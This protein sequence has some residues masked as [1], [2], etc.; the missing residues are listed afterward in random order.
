MKPELYSYQNTVEDRATGGVYYTGEADASKLADYTIGRHLHFLNGR[1]KLTPAYLR[2]LRI[3]DPACGTGPLLW[4]A[5]RVLKAYDTWGVTGTHNL[6]GMDVDEGALHIFE[7][8]AKDASIYCG[9]ALLDIEKWPECNFIVSNPPYVFLRRGS[10][11]KRKDE[12]FQRRGQMKDLAEYFVSEGCRK[13]WDGWTTCAGFLVQSRVCSITSDAMQEINRA[14]AKVRIGFGT[15]E[16]PWECGDARTQCHMFG[17][18]S[19]YSEAPVEFDGKPT[20]AIHPGLRTDVNMFALAECSKEM[21][22]RVFLGSSEFKRYPDNDM[23][24]E[25]A[26]VSYLTGQWFMNGRGPVCAPLASLEDRESDSVLRSPMNGVAPDYW[27]ASCSV[28]KYWY[29]RTVHVGTFAAALNI[30]VLDGNY[31]LMGIVQSRF[32]RLWAEAMSYSRNEHGTKSFTVYDA[33]RTFP[34]PRDYRYFRWQ[35]DL[36]LKDDYGV[37][38]AMKVLEDQRQEAL[39]NRSVVSLYNENPS[40]LRARHHALDCA[41]AEVLGLPVEVLSETD[42]QVLQRLEQGNRNLAHYYTAT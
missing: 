12:L 42:A 27:M 31:L 8:W 29:W 36:L 19:R 23:S 6:I 33:I 4:A 37:E 41:V 5:L 1:N 26:E 30:V 20:Y 21:Y 25:Q 32:M 15:K 39:F 34:F 35:T 9:D 28:A 11:Y 3:L 40:W 17:L 2:D 13:V 38:N 7:S 14:D 22:R 16:F 24:E 10:P 18:E